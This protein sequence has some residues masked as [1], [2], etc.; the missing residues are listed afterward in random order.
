M[1]KIPLASLVLTVVLIPGAAASTLSVQ[2]PQTSSAGTCATTT[3]FGSAGTFTVCVSDS[4][5]HVHQ[6]ELITMTMTNSGILGGNL[7]FYNAKLAISN[8]GNPV[9]SSSQSCPSQFSCPV[10]P[11]QSLTITFSWTATLPKGVDVVT[12][13]LT[14]DFGCRVFGCLVANPLPTSLQVN[15]FVK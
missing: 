4:T 2:Q 8:N 3:L 7:L 12:G 13:T 5:L 10:A 11:G 9:F 1:R 6:T 14:W 15:V